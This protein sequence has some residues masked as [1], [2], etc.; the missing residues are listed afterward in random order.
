MFPTEQI[1]PAVNFD[2]KMLIAVFQGQK[3]SGRYSIEINKIKEYADYIEVTVRE[4]SPGENCIVTFAL[5]S[6][7]HIVEVEKSDKPIRFTFEQEITRCN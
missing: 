6:P 7:L 4:T 5:T 3:P 1:A 2:E